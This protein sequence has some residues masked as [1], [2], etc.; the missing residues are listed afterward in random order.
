MLYI[1]TLRKKYRKNDN[2]ILFVSLTELCNY[3]T[4]IDHPRYECSLVES[5][6]S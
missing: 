4:A 1:P 3:K 6:T 2:R 5:L